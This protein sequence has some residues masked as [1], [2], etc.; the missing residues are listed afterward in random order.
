MGAILIVAHKGREA[1]HLVR[2]LREAGH[3]PIFAS[4]SRAALQ[5]ALECPDLILLDLE[6]VP[7]LSGEEL[8]G[9]LKGH[10]KTAQIPVLILAGRTG[11]AAHVGGGDSGRGAAILIKPVSGAQLREAV[12][13][14]LAGRDG[15]DADAVRAAH[16]RRQELIER[17][18][19]E[20]PD[21][22][23]FHVYRR[24]CADRRRTRWSQRSDALTWT[25]IAEWAKRE[26]VLDAEQASLL[27]HIPPS[28]AGQA[29]EGAA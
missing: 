22:L 3:T 11:A 29:E 26:G 6:G 21:P 12:E 7:E 18:I 1:G 24:L 28:R 19:V 16:Q 8:L 9:R 17:L 4:D 2:S 14:A 10:L 20:G 25:E 5:E 27:R 23:V 13:I 15:L